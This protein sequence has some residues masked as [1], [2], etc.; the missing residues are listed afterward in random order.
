MPRPHGRPV[1]G[2]RPFQPY[3]GLT[4]TTP[5]PPP[6]EDGQGEL[7]TTPPQVRQRRSAYGDAILEATKKMRPPARPV[8]TYQI[9]DVMRSQHATLD[10][11]DRRRLYA[12]A[13]NA[14]LAVREL[15]R[16]G[17]IKTP[18]EEDPHP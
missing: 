8:D 17:T 9:E 14:W 10:H 11:L 4:H 16:D 2:R 15:R 5:W 6:R 1:S 7:F 3:P 18:T 12:L 13:R